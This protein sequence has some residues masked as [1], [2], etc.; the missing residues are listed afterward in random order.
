MMCRCRLAAAY[1]GPQQ[2]L[3]GPD[4]HPWIHAGAFQGK[5]VMLLLD[6]QKLST[7]TLAKITCLH[8]DF[9]TE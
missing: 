7:C 2:V 4:E 9:A 1:G 8:A 5:Y 3:G 6:R